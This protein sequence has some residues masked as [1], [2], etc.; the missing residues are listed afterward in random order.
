[1]PGKAGLTRPPCAPRQD[2]FPSASF[3]HFRLTEESEETGFKLHYQSTRGAL[4]APFVQG[5]IS[6]VSTEL[7]KS[8]VLSPAL[9]PGAHSEP[10][11]RRA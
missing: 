5:L 7:F 1:M 6:A 9:A 10:P 2:T 8:E 3:P 11:R 4:L